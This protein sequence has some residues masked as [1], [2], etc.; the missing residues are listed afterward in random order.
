M[1]EEPKETKGSEH[2]SARAA[3]E[4]KASRC[5]TPTW[6]C[7][8]IA[9][10]ANQAV[11][12]PRACSEWADQGECE[13]NPAFMTTNCAAWCAD[14]S[15]QSRACS[16]WANQ[17]ECERNPAFM[18]THCAAWCATEGCAAWASVGECARNPPCFHE[19]EMRSQEP[20]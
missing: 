11:A 19:Q 6:A 10:M 17:G 3:A 4:Q 18:A 5:A 8:V 7:I 12:D 9:L 15:H 20:P 14:I 2:R 16:E 1:T 13:R